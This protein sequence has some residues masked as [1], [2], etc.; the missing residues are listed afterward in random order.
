[1]DKIP[2]DERQ[3]EGKIWRMNR[4]GGK[5]PRWELMIPL[6]IG[7]GLPLMRQ[8]LRLTPKY[9]PYIYSATVLSAFAYGLYMNLHLARTSD[10][11]QKRPGGPPPPSG[12]DKHWRDFKPAVYHQH[13]LGFKEGVEK[14]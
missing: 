14:Y 3:V 13:Y 12:L 11:H 5:Y 6:L 7:P 1:M 2:L 10:P 8:A 9:R 4:Q